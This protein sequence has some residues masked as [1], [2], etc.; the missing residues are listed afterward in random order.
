MNPMLTCGCAAN[1]TSEGKPGCAVHLCT[2]VAPTPDLTGRV[3]VCYGHCAKLPSTPSLA[4]FVYRGEGS[5]S[6]AQ[7]ATCGCVQEAHLPINPHTGRE[8]ITGHPYAP[9]GPWPTDSYYC[10]CMGWD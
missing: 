10:G 8:G 2:E 5:P 4:F 9:R 3:A 6:A 7:C 1:A